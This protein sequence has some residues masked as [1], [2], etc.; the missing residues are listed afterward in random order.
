MCKNILLIGGTGTLST[1]VMKRAVMCGYNVY[2]LNRGNHN[3]MLLPSVIPLIADFYDESSIRKVIEGLSFAVVVD[4]LSRK[5][6]DVER[7]LLLF[8]NVEQYIFISSA[9]VYR[10]SPEDGILTENAPKPNNNWSYSIEKLRCEEVLMELSK[11]YGIN[12]TIVRPY[13]TYDNKR[14][15][16][17]LAPSHNTTHWTII[18]RILSGKPMFLWDDGMTKCTLTHVDDFSIGLVGLFENPQAYNEDFHIVTDKSLSW[19]DMLLLL[20]EMLGVKPNIIFVPTDYICHCL[21]EY[22]GMLLGDR[23]LN[24][25]FDIA[26]LK[27]AVPCFESSVSLK[28]GLAEVIAYYRTHNFLDGIDYVWD[29]KI[30]RLISSYGKC[31]NLHYRDYLGE[32]RMSNYWKYL[33]GRHVLFLYLNR[34]YVFLRNRLWRK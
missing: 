23:A 33:I 31:Y 20:Y 4:F 3:E 26:K 5:P 22:R 17:G 15:P 18:A 30:D 19:L 32:K 25:E 11:N 27:K 34:V 21:P 13:I 7:T 8:L 9:C 29:G 1:A 12:Y 6:Q 28:M 24:A 2:V 10:R 14:I 16:F